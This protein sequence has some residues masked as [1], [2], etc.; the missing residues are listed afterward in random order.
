LLVKENQRLNKTLAEKED[1][2]LDIDDLKKAMRDKPTDEQ[3]LITQNEKL[4]SLN[5]KLNLDIQ[6][7][8]SKLLNI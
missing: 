6:K 1:E 8:K 3:G 4:I 5:T 7:M 2:N